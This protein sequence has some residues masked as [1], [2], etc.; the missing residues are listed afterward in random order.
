MLKRTKLGLSLA[1]SLLISA[2]SL[3]AQDSG[4]LIDLLTRKGIINDQEAEE[5]RAELLKEFAANTPAGKLDMSSALT[6]FRI[7]GDLRTRFQYDNEEGNPAGVGLNQDRSRYRYRF[8]LG[9]TATLGAKWTAGLR[10]ESQTS[11]TSTNNDFASGTDNFGKV[12]D[13]AQ[14]GQVFIQY[15]DTNFLGADAVDFRLGKFSHKFFNPGINGFWIDS[16][17]NFE[18]LAQE[19][20][21]NGV[22]TKDGILSLRAGQFMLNANS[23]QG[24]VANDPSFL[25]ILQAE[26]ATKTLKVAPTFTFFAAPSAHDTGAPFSAAQA[27]DTTVYNNLATILIPAEYTMT[28]GSQPFAIYGTVGLNLE[29]RAR[30]KRLAQTDAVDEDG[31]IGNLGVRYGNNKLAGEQMFTAE[32]RYVGN[33]AYSSL[34][35]DSDFNGGLLNSSGGILSYSYNITDAI[36]FTSTYFYAFNIEEDRAPG[37]GNRGNGFGKAQV[38]QIDLSAKF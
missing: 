14:V 16:D 35:L 36:N 1:A 29:D 32:Y 4:A 34:L 2:G 23:G 11:A 37:G 31:L 9:T 21:F 6:K 7:A 3:I 26:F 17:I 12:T 8:R 19:L 22:F 28:L 38:L 30:A 13:A 24:A 25:H 5:L 20:V 27:N 18:G 15:N 33:G 10:L